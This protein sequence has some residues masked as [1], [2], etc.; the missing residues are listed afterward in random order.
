VY[1]ED[2]SVCLRTEGTCRLRPGLNEQVI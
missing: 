1:K 2:T